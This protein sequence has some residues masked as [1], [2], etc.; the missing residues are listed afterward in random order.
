MA[1]AS[2]LVKVSFGP[3]VS[4]GITSLIGAKV[5]CPHYGGQDCFESEVEWIIFMISSVRWRSTL[6]DL[7]CFA[8]T[9][10]AAPTLP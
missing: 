10:H 8:T 4:K 9:L 3:C 1:W 5:K 6:S 2:Q 7:T